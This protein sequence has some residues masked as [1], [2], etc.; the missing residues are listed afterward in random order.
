MVKGSEIIPE[1]FR[2][3][4]KRLGRKWKEKEIN[5]VIEEETK[6]LSSLFAPVAPHHGQSPAEINLCQTPIDF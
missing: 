4:K 5:L 1:N 3:R 6:A 2:D